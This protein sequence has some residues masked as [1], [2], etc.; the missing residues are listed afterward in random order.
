MGGYV[1]NELKLNANINPSITVGALM[2]F[3]IF[4]YLLVCELC[5]Q[6]KF[7]IRH[8][9]KSVKH[10]V[11]HMSLKIFTVVRNV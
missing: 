11:I 5:P 3:M 10:N 8:I 6:Q 9:Y 7:P 2:Y 4:M 1:F